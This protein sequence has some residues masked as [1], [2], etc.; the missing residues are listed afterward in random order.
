[1]TA[2]SLKYLSIETSFKIL[3]GP[4]NSFGLLFWKIYRQ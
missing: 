2:R 4:L 1:L 3:A